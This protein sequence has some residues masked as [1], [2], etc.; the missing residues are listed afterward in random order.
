MI[1]TNLVLTVHIREADWKAVSALPLHRLTHP[2]TLMHGVISLPL[3][4]PLA[5]ADTNRMR[6]RDAGLD[7]VEV[8]EESQAWATG[9]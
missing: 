8:A 1:S 5:A 4:A 7:A 6:K 3:T 2:P 9:G